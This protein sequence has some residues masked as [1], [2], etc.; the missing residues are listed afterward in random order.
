MKNVMLTTQEGYT[1]ACDCCD[2]MKG[3]GMKCD[4]V[5]VDM[6]YA[7]IP[8]NKSDAN[9]ELQGKFNRERFGL[10]GADE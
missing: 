4:C 7:P 6:N 2:D 8:Q 9:V 10:G 3:M 5:A 1:K